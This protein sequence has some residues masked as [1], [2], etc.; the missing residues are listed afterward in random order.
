VHI[1]F[2]G[3]SDGEII[4]EVLVV[5]KRDHFQMLRFTSRYTTLHRVLT[6]EHLKRHAMCSFRTP[7]IMPLMHA[8]WTGQVRHARIAHRSR[9]GPRPTQRGSHSW[10]A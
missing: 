9:R 4:G 8:P 1:C 3:E 10:L 6:P 2:M 7:L 5:V